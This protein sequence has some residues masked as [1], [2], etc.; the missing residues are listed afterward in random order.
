MVVKHTLWYLCSTTARVMQWDWDVLHGTNICKTTT[1][2]ILLRGD[3]FQ[4]V[5]GGMHVQVKD[6]T[7]TQL[8]WNLAVSAPCRLRDH[9][10]V[11]IFHAILVHSLAHPWHFFLQAIPLLRAGR[12]EVL[13]EYLLVAE[14]EEA[15]VDLMQLQVLFRL[16]QTLLFKELSKGYL[17]F[18][19]FAVVPFILP[20]NYVFPWV[21]LESA[22][23]LY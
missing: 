22:S 18:N 23:V 16:L 9:R 21:E 5:L 1:A 8:R 2:K 4:C 13:L 7:L 10:L 20:L 3:S 17:F 12:F 6:L 15:I 19:G 14:E 11:D